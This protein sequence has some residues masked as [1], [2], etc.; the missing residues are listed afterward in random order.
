[1]YGDAL[2]EGIVSTPAAKVPH[3]YF[4]VARD[5]YGNDMGKAD[6]R[7]EFRAYYERGD[8]LLV[9]TTENWNHALRTVARHEVVRVDDSKSLFEVRFEY[10]KG[11]LH[12]WETSFFP[13]PEDPVSAE[14]YVKYPRTKTTGLEI[15]GTE[16]RCGLCET[17]LEIKCQNSVRCYADVLQVPPSYFHPSDASVSVVRGEGITGGLANDGELRPAD[18]L[19]LE[20]TARALKL[21]VARARLASRT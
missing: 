21:M 9:S 5:I 16:A 20:P 4:I 7:G 19:T 10:L 6:I 8:G 17:N 14:A 12:R 18:V 11:G 15:T 3:K 2:N 13:D 1:M